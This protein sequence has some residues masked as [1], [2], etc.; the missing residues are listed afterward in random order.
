MTLS[1]Q[2]GMQ[3]SGG[4]WQLHVEAT[5]RGCSG[6]QQ[7]LKPA[8]FGDAL[9]VTAGVQLTRSRSNSYASPS[10]VFIGKHQDHGL[11]YTHSISL[12]LHLGLVLPC[13]IKPI[14]LLVFCTLLHWNAQVHMTG[15]NPCADASTLPDN[16][17]LY[18]V[19][20][21]CRLTAQ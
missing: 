9:R 3:H 17:A 15:R 19:L 4:A 11:Q 21:K 2:L 18:S 7:G 10:L 5:Y 20:C 8:A 13:S 14:W 1:C 6:Q 12:R 16:I